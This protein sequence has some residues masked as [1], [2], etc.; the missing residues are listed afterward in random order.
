MPSLSLKASVN[1]PF[2]GGGSPGPSFD[3]DAAAWFSAVA[4]NGGTITGSLSSGNKKAFNDAFLSLK[5]TSSTKGGSLWSRI[6]QGYWLIGQEEDPSNP[7]FIDPASNGL[8]VPWGN[9]MIY[10]GVGVNYGFSGYTKKGGVVGDGGSFFDTQAAQNV[11]SKWPATNRHGYAYLESGGNLSYGYPFGCY[12]QDFTFDNN[13][14][15]FGVSGYQANSVAPQYAVGGFYVNG[16]GSDGVNIAVI[17]TRPMPFSSGGWGIPSTGSISSQQKTIV[18]GTGKVLDT[19]LFPYS[20]TWYSAGSTNAN[21]MALGATTSP[22]NSNFNAL[23]GNA[24][25]FTFGLELSTAD[26]TSLDNIVN[27]LKSALA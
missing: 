26:F 14:F 13:D 25:V 20:Q 17:P 15:S 19:S 2:I 3:P 16:Y 12:S 8:F 4:A 7:G 24:L 5:S 11:T 18:T 1:Y 21:T 22:L 23:T 27:T 9:N 6:V 10:S